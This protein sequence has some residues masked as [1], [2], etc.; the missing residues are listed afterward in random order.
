MIQFDEGKEFYNVGVKKL[1]R[2][3]Y[4]VKYFSTHTGKKAA[5]VERFNRSLKTM[6]WKLF[7]VKETHEWLNELN[8]LVSNYN[9]TKHRGIAMKPADVNESNKSE[10]WIRLF[11]QPVGDIPYPK[12]K[13]GD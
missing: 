11:G 9:N 6:M 3:A 12:F 8:S 5:I 1:L 4:N 13:I 7:N 2:D 10:I